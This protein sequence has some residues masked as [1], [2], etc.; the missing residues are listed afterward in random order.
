MNKK[1]IH[2][3]TPLLYL[4]AIAQGQNDFI[5]FESR[6]QTLANK[7]LTSDTDSL[8]FET[9]HL[10]IENLEEILLLKGS[11]Q[12]DFE[13]IDNMSIL[14]SPDRKFKLYNW[15][16]PKEDG[17]FD[18]FAYIQMLKRKK[19]P[20]FIKLTDISDEITQEQYNILTSGEW[21][22]SLYSEIIHTKFEKKNY[23]TLLGWDGNNKTSTKKIVEIMH[24]DEEKKPVFGAQIIKMN[25]GT[26]SR[27]ILE[28]SK[29]A[30]INMGYNKD[31]D[32]IIFDHLE[33]I[34]TS[35]KGMYEFYI[36]SL[37]FDGLTFK[38]GKW[39]FVEDIQVYNNKKFNLKQ[40]K[41]IERG[42]QPN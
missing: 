1:I 23:Y 5:F 34:E 31:N 28:Y 26:R 41:N 16:V 35:Q 20:F 11:F 8:K 24:F 3:L 14:I 18:Y 10:L 39:R 12:Y 37:S 32:Y 29:N 42:L 25:D 4:C 36:P 40:L 15:V 7:I 22:G 33:P 30:S 27:M 19:E 2:L 6:I 13:N 38:N 21:Y 9:N 17:S